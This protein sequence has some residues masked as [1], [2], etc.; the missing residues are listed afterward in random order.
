[1]IGRRSLFS[2]DGLDFLEGSLDM[3]IA[4]PETLRSLG[5]VTSK[6]TFT[7]E[8]LLWYLAASSKPLIGTERL[9][10]RASLQVERRNRPFHDRK[11][12]ITPFLLF[13]F[14]GLSLA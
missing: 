11:R 3:G 5:K 14:D 12:A 4:D 7:F 8:N 1:M 13:S 9:S 2:R 10:W 6:L